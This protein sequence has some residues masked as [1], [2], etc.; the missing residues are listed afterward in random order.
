MRACQILLLKT[1]CNKKCAEG[2]RG[3]LQN[4]VVAPLSLLELLFT[5]G[6][7][8]IICIKCPDAFP[9]GLL[10]QAQEKRPA[11]TTFRQSLSLSP[12]LRPEGLDSPRLRTSNNIASRWHLSL[13]FTPGRRFR[14]TTAFR[15]CEAH[16][17][18]RP[19]S[20]SSSSSHSTSERQVAVE[21]PR[22][23]KIRSHH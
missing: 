8:M 18:P 15:N 7:R 11:R 3:T 4:P 1:N 6:E 9:F 19:E 17:A 22:M 13:C 12:P 20:G 21:I 23:D 5:P 10:Q 16:H 14:I 2:F